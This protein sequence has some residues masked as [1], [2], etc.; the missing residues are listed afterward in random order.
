MNRNTIVFVVLVLSFLGSYVLT[1]YDVQVI[2][3][4]IVDTWTI[5]DGWATSATTSLSVTITSTENSVEVPA[6]GNLTFS[7]TGISQVIPQVTQLTSKC[8]INS[9]LYGPSFPS[10]W[11]QREPNAT[12]AGTKIEY[13][14]MNYNCTLT[15]QCRIYFN[16]SSAVMGTLNASNISLFFYNSSTT[17]WD[18]LSTNVIS[19][20]NNPREFFAFVGQLL[21]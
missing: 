7:N 19:A 3:N 4:T 9:T 20:T 13:F 21:T 10:A 1:S 8:I 18:N 6:S 11:S 17:N 15:E 12:E 5:I 2:G 14:D 16:V